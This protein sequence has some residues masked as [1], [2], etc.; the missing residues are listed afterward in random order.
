MDKSDDS[1]GIVRYKTRGEKKAVISIL[2]SMSRD[3]Y[4]EC[5]IK[6]GKK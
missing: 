3:V 5:L 2:I 6:S 4:R 1:E